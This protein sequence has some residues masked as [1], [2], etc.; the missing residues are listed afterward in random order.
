MQIRH[1]WLIVLLSLCFLT[2]AYAGDK[3]AF[4]TAQE[5]ESLYKGM[6][7]SVDRQARQ[8][9]VNDHTFQLTRSTRIYLHNGEPSSFWNLSPGMQVGLV[10][11]IGEAGAQRGKVNGQKVFYLSKIVILDSTR[12]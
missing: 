1:L 11:E 9:Y 8:I 2:Q 4:L 3:R 6:L 12:D 5:E 10:V 7:Q